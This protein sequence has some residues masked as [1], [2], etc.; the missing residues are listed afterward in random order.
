MAMSIDG[1]FAGAF[2]LLDTPRLEAKEAISW[3]RELGV[4]TA[5][6]SGDQ[7]VVVENI[8]AELGIDDVYAEQL[9]NDK[10]DLVADL[11]KQG[12]VV[13]FVGDGINDA[14]ALRPRIQA[15]VSEQGRTSR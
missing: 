6:A 2:G 13:A 5:I 15:L 12:H 10:S 3:L 8:A 4:K 1:A 7:R 11:Q 14:P 9:P